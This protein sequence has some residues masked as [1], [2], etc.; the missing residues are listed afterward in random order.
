VWF[1]PFYTDEE[2][3]S[4]AGEIVEGKPGA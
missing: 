4:F 3:D 2:L 1:D